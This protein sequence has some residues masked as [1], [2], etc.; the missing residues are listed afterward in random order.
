MRNLETEKKIAA[1]IK[2]QREQRER[3]LKN[4]SLVAKTTTVSQ[5][6][7][8]KSRK[9]TEAK[10]PPHPAVH[11]PVPTVPKHSAS[12]WA[13]KQGTV[14]R[15]QYLS[16]S[17]NQ[18]VCFCEGNL[19]YGIFIPEI[20]LGSG[21][22]GEALLYKLDIDLS[23]SSVK[24]R[25]EKL[26][27]KTQK[28]YTS[29]IFPGLELYNEALCWLEQD[30]WAGFFGDEKSDKSMHA[31]AVAYKPGDTLH[32]IAAEKQIKSLEHFL[33]I[34]SAIVNA[35]DNFHKKGRG[36]V[37]GDLNSGNIIIRELKDDG[38]IEVDLIDYGFCRPIGWPTKKFDP[39]AHK[40]PEL[41]KGIAA[42]TDQD[43][44]DLGYLL[45]YYYKHKHL[46]LPENKDL[47]V[48][49]ADM[50]KVN[51]KERPNLLE[52]QNRI[53]LIEKS[54]KPATPQIPTVDEKTHRPDSKDQESASY[55][56]S[57]SSVSEK[58]SRKVSIDDELEKSPCSNLVTLYSKAHS[59]V[60]SGESHAALIDAKE[61][62][63]GSSGPFEVHICEDHAKNSEKDSDKSDYDYDYDDGDVGDDDVAVD[64]S[65]CQ[66][67]WID[68]D[69][70]S[71][72]VDHQYRN[73]EQEDTE[74]LDIEFSPLPSKLS[75][76][77]E[78]ENID[79]STLD[80]VDL[81]SQPKV[82][83]QRTI[84]ESSEDF[85]HHVQT[86]T[87][88]SG[89]LSTVF[90]SGIFGETRRIKLSRTSSLFDLDASSPDLSV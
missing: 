23:G 17:T 69:V 14:T 21:A 51:P 52:V 78:L 75:N 22:Y 30:G 38:K 62:K 80:T 61:D 48:L 82:N 24:G 13:P 57:P 66:V 28:P 86:E 88:S 44:F 15:F 9:K 46:N 50:Q 35:I 71:P 27:I 4:R 70:V 29:G 37:H 32:K 10:A 85:S 41:G 6:I 83:L 65:V 90:G 59:S 45:N 84:S 5:T 25:P 16:N 2:A 58:A 56:L 49:F 81:D 89:V 34:F 11:T 12:I 74:S 3:F 26:V 18:M 73:I 72:V 19:S 40:A 55:F 76:P 79:E 60:T 54:L 36:W 87:Y 31:L 8:E 47:D 42:S 53:S 64:E 20:S 1:G 67:T 77:D 68:S 39:V 33:K 43:V 63:S 7:A